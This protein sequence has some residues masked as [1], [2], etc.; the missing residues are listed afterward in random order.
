LRNVLGNLAVIQGSADL[1]GWRGLFAGRPAVVASAGPS[2]PAAFDALRAHQDRLLIVA[3]D[4][5]LKPLL[6][7]GIRPHIITSK[8]R[9]ERTIPLLE[10]VDAAGITLAAL[11]L[12]PP[13]AF[14]VWTGDVTS[15]F[16]GAAHF[17][18]LGTIGLERDVLP[19]DGSAGNMAFKVCEA[20]GCDP[21]I[22][23]G[24]DLSFSDSGET[25]AAGIDNAPARAVHLDQQRLEVP[26]NRGGG[27]S[28]APLWLEFLQ[29]FETDVHH[30]LGVC[31]NAT[32]RG[33][34]IRGAPAVD[35]NEV[36]EVLSE[37]FDARAM[38]DAARMPPPSGPNLY[39]G[40]SWSILAAAKIATTCEESA[41]FAEVMTHSPPSIDAGPW[42]MNLLLG[43]PLAKIGEMRASVVRHELFHELITPIAQSSALQTE[44]AIYGLP[45][46]CQDPA[47]LV[48]RAASGWAGWFRTI[49]KIARMTESLLKSY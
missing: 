22:L 42:D 33:A 28:T 29:I 45:R 5:S 40:V 13:R 30:F 31:L 12:L 8:E 10:G 7:A 36:L 49:G 18:W 9:S 25:H 16:G 24:Q 11:P 6:A 39:D 32:Q 19:F 38:L 48:V 21:I 15:V 3:P 17:L 27:V 4:T 1:S 37:P 26:G 44:M 23:V 35:L 20:L 47:E 14:D 41:A 43:G 2:L 34:R 46:N